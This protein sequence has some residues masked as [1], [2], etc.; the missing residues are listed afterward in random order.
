MLKCAIISDLAVGAPYEGDGAVYI[1]RGSVNGIIEE[2][3]QRIYAADLQTA[4]PLSSFGYTLSG[5][6]DMDENGYPDLA[7]GS[8][9]VNKALILRTRPI[10]TPQVSNIW[11]WLTNMYMG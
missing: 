2:P 7:V 4:R 6:L 8:F 1:F 10:I 9:G 3:S 11:I 5:G